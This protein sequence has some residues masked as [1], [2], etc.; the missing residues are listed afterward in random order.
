M[1]LLSSA[2]LREA[3]PSSTSRDFVNS[4]ES[5]IEVPTFDDQDWASQHSPALV[6]YVRRRKHKCTGGLI[7]PE[8][9]THIDVDGRVWTYADPG[10]LPP[11]VQCDAEAI[12]ASPST[13]NLCRYPGSKLVARVSPKTLREL[14]QV[15][16]RARYTRHVGALETGYQETLLVTGTGRPDGSSL[17]VAGCSVGAS[18]LDSPE[19]SFIIELFRRV[20]RGATLEAPCREFRKLGPLELGPGLRAWWLN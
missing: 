13:R 1:P 7:R 12:R 15:V 2:P 10:R 3:S 8:V 17:L 16:A 5:D 20:R 9:G 6:E 18:Q 4:T 14:K 19:G 11:G